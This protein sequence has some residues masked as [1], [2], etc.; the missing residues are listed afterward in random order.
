MW[1][2]GREEGRERGEKGGRGRKGIEGGAAWFVQN[3]EQKNLTMYDT[4]TPFQPDTD[5]TIIPYAV[6]RNDKKPTYK[7]I[8]IF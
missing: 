1:K 3:T 2:A 4:V 7:F 6:E 5:K 8:K